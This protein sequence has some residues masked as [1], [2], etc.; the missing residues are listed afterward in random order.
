MARSV[1]T[2]FLHGFRFHADIVEETDFLNNF[3][4]TVDGQPQAGFSAITTPEAT[5]EA[6]EYREGTDVYTRKFVGVPSMADVTLSRGATRGD[7]SFWRWMRAGM[8]GTGEYRANLDIKHFHRDQVLTRGLDDIGTENL[9]KF[10]A[11]LLP[12][13]VYH[14]KQGFPI[15]HKVSGD[16]DATAS[17]I[18]VMEL[19]V[20]Y[21]SFE[22]EE[23]AP[24]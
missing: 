23:L 17:E 13:R 15:R 18:S 9:T 11:G 21:E 6:V 22:V 10:D 8:E 14:L 20:S 12:G 4:F 16:L 24:V 7:S 2:D 19:D 1:Q 5:T 3:T